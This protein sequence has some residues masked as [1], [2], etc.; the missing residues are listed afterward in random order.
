MIVNNFKCQYHVH[1]NIFKVTIYIVICL[2]PPSAQRKRK[3]RHVKVKNF[4]NIPKHFCKWNLLR[5]KC[6]CMVINRVFIFKLTAQCVIFIDEYHAECMR[7]E[8]SVDVM[9]WLVFLASASRLFWVSTR[10][11]NV[12]YYVT[13][14]V[15]YWCNANRNAENI[16]MNYHWR[17]LVISRSDVMTLKYLNE[18]KDT[19]NYN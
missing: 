10:E 5:R 12:T 4:L 18:Y 6:N 8:R 11:F 1:V 13:F 3:W 7:V 15:M 19:I 14:I 16:L 17:H 9:Y 2:L